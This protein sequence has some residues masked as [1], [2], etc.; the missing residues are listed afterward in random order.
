M[1]LKKTMQTAFGLECVNAYHRVE[2]LRFDSKDRITFQLRASKDGVLP[3]FNDV[4]MSCDYDIEGDNPIRQAYIFLK[5]QPE[6]A[7]AEDC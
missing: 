4:Q 5:L 7:N 1:A 2:G 3:H 6:F